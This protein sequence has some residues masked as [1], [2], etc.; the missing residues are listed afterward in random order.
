MAKKNSKKRSLNNHQIITLAGIGLV[1]ILLALFIIF[2]AYPKVH[3]QQRLARIYDI[4]GSV[5]LD[6][7]KCSIIDETVFGDKRVY[8][9]DK[10]RTYSSEVH[11]TCNWDVATT[12]EAIKETVRNSDFTFQEEPYP[13]SV[14]WQYVYK[15][16]KNE[17]MRINAGSKPWA[18]ALFND[19]RM[20]GKISDETFAIDKNSGPTNVSIK[21]NL[22]DNNE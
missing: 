22:D 21:V 13:G 11:Y 3:S 14:D 17:Y 16:P 19:L 20:T 1:V 2:F 6:A 4:Y 8:E 12:I 15:S 9:W 7:D 18:D 5:A 10:S